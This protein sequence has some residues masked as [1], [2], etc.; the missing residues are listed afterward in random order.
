MIFLWGL[1]RSS[2]ARVCARSHVFPLVREEPPALPV[3]V[4]V[5]EV[6]KQYEQAFSALLAVFWKAIPS[7]KSPLSGEAAHAG[8][9]LRWV[10]LCSPVSRCFAESAAKSVKTVGKQLQQYRQDKLNVILEDLDEAQR[11]LFDNL[12]VRL[13]CAAAALLRCCAAHALRTCG[14]TLCFVPVSCRLAQFRVDTAIA[15]YERLTAGS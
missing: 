15:M 3:S 4:K 9:G 14:L 11:P 12:K 10:C 7:D 5:A 13:G 8:G 1:G 6:V 2:R